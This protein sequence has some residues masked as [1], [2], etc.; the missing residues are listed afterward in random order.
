MH[1]EKCNGIFHDDPYQLILGINTKRLATLELSCTTLQATRASQS[2]QNNSDSCA[3]H[4][5]I[6]AAKPVRSF[7][8]RNKY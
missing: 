7:V 1:Q 3:T 2:L 5:Q 6:S 4:L 8:Y